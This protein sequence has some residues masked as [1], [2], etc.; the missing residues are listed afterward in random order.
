ML[1]VYP[2]LLVCMSWIFSVGP[3][4]STYPSSL[5]LSV[6]CGAYPSDFIKEFSCPPAFNMVEPLGVIGKMLEDGKKLLPHPP[7]LKVQQNLSMFL[8]QRPQH[9]SGKVMHGPRAVVFS[10]SQWLFSVVVSEAFE[11]LMLQII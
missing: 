1:V 8:S 2:R 10:Q 3:P 9:L 4:Q 6:P 5:L 11:W 7:S